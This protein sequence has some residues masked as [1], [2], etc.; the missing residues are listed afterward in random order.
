VSSEQHSSFRSIDVTLV[1]S[2]AQDDSSAW[3]AQIARQPGVKPNTLSASANASKCFIKS[4]RQ[5][6]S[7]II[8]NFVEAAKHIPTALP[9]AAP[10]DYVIWDL[11]L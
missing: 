11:Y 1:S 9:P 3:S 7:V 10:H 5:F 8:V 2:E 4:R 6:I